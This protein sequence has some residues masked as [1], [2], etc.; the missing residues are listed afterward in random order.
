MATDSLR[1]W[2]AVYAWFRRWARCDD[3][4]IAEGVSDAVSTLLAKH[5]GATD[6]LAAL[7]RKDR[8]FADFVV[9]HLDETVPA[10][11]LR[12]ISASARTAC[13]DRAT[14]LCIRIERATR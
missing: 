6:H 7:G 2:T 5:W 14:V 4:S 10:D 11:R 9:R 8:L 3:A 1:N 12:T 13:P